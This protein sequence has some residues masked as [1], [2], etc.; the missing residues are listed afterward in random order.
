M[1]DPQ[2]VFLA[3]KIFGEWTGVTH[4]ELLAALWNNLSREDRHV[5]LE[6]ADE[7]LKTSGPEG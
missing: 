7:V 4:P 3:R 2:R 1:T 5:W 6:R